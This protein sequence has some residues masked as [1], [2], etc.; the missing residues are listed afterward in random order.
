MF[1]ERFDTRQPAAEFYPLWT[2]AIGRLQCVLRQGRPRIDVGILRTDHFVDNLSGVAVVDPDGRRVPDEEL[3]ARRWMRDRQNHWWSDLGMQDAGWTYEF[4]DGSL[5]Q[6]PEISFAD[7]LVQPDGPG[8]QA[9]V[10]YQSELDPDVA[11][12]L[13]EQARQGLRVL[14]VHG[15]REARLVMADRYVTHERAA[16]RTPGLDGR[17]EELV[18]TIAAL[19]ALPTVAE[20]DDP[21]LAVEALRGLGVRGRAEFVADD[22]EVLTHLREDGDLLHLYAY[23]F[24]YETGRPT[25]LEVS[26]DGIGVPYRIDA[27]SGQVFP[28]AGVRYADDRTVV[29]LD[30]APGET[31]LLTVDRSAGAGAESPV[32][33]REVIA[34][35]ADWEFA[36][37]SWDAGEPDLISEDRGLGYVSREVRPTTAITRLAVG[38]SA[39]RPW[40]EA[41][42]VGPE[43]SGVGDYRTSVV[44]ESAPAAGERILLDLGSVAGGLGSATVNGGP[45]RGF[46]TSRPVVDVT[47]DVRAGANEIHVRV[48]SS[49]NNRLLARGYYDKVPDVALQ[50]MNGDSD[51]T[52][53]TE[54]HDHGLLGPVRLLREA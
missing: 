45:A 14:L 54:P 25:R 46:D 32:A 3:Y 30:L 51:A 9:L 8:Y 20:V 6:R 27:W 50:L 15:A 19:V 13:L 11:T 31:A 21:S 26:L 4:F 44:L 42:E 43:V 28:H 38:S 41:A 17:D 48:A 39:L 16:A 52:Q 2:S 12:L 24:R 40:Q 10:V 22:V 29:T 5:L 1:S 53:Q 34:D 18:A 47:S 23:S 36:V 7:G 33:G 37:E 49:L 35:L